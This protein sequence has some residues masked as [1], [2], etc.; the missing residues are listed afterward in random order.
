MRKITEKMVKNFF[1]CKTSRTDNTVVQ[2]FPWIVNMYLFGNHIATYWIKDW[3][4]ELYD[5]HHQT[6]TTKERLNW[7][8]EYKRLGCIF[9]KG[10]EWFY[11]NEK[12]KIRPFG[13]G[14]SRSI[15][16]SNK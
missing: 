6:A 14:I 13:K 4:V 8:L 16:N 9:Q 15:L 12:W 2:C 1:N 11:W 10:W 7:I 3:V 5:W